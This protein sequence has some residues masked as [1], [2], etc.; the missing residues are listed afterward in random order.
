MVDLVCALAAPA[1]YL[2]V[3]R[4]DIN[5]FIVAPTELGAL[6]GVVCASIAV[7]VQGA[8]LDLDGAWTDK[9]GAVHSTKAAAKGEFAHRAPRVGTVWKLLASGRRLCRRRW[10]TGFRW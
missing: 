7:I 9:F 2:G 8:V 1:L 10:I 5:S 3:I 4:E 6:M